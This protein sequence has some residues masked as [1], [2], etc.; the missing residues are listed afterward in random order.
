MKKNV[1]TVMK[2]QEDLR[3]NKAKEANIQKLKIYLSK[4]EY[5]RKN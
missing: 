3:L 2:L 4:N 1:E 5:Q